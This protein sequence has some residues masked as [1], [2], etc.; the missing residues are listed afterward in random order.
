[1][2]V[3]MCTTLKLA[4]SLLICKQENTSSDSRCPIN[5]PSVVIIRSISKFQQVLN[6]WPFSADNGISSG[7]WTWASLISIPGWSP[8]R[9]AT[10][11]FWP[12]VSS[13]VQKSLKRP[14]SPFWTWSSSSATRRDVSGKP[15]TNI[16]KTTARTHLDSLIIIVNG[17]VDVWRCR[18]CDHFVTMVC[19]CVHVG[20]CVVV[21]GM[22][23]RWNVNPRTESHETWY[24][25]R[26][27]HCVKA[28]WYWV[29]KIKGQ[30]HRVIILNFWHQLPPS[31]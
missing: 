12:L 6:F 9:R 18:Y 23:S 16:P 24:S 11:C 15:Y 19:V 14:L 7:S 20:R 10:M 31:K 2:C 21:Y 13:A 30:G 25:S 4:F 5:P 27:R 28:Y 26:S 29:Q 8:C 17:T 22:L 3:C 1:M